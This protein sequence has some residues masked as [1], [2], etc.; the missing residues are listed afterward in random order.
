MEDTSVLKIAKTSRSAIDSLANSKEEFNVIIA[1]LDKLIGDNSQQVRISN[2]ISN[3]SQ[4]GLINKL[5][6]HRKR[7]CDMLAEM[8]VIKEDAW[9]ALRPEA[10]K[11][12]E[13]AA[14]AMKK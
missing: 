10:A 4:V 1:K 13:E 2:D 11:V 8:E 9:E 3:A 14:S 5:K 12:Y 7:L 6:I